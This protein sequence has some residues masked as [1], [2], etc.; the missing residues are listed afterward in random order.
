MLIVIML[1]YVEIEDEE[2]IA[3]GAASLSSEESLKLNDS[4]NIEENLPESPD[5]MLDSLERIEGMNAET[6]VKID[7]GPSDVL[8]ASEADEE[9]EENAIK[10]M[11]GDEASDAEEFEVAALALQLVFSK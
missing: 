2:E 4:F 8:Q 6:K 10:E 1:R 7:D 9:E 3:V 11:F 5:A